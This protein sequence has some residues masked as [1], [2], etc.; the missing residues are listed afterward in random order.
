ME[1]DFREGARGG[2]APGAAPALAVLS[3]ATAGAEPLDP[4]ALLER[5]FALEP[6]RVLRRMPGRETF[7]WPAGEAFVVK[8]YRGEEARDFLYERLRRARRPRSPGRRE[9]ENLAAL[10]A[11]GFDVPRALAWAEERGALS[12]AAARPEAPGARSAVVMERIPFEASFGDHLRRIPAAARAPWLER[13]AVLVARLHARGWYH[14]DLYLHQIV[15]G[16]GGDLVLLD[17][18]RARRERAPRR[19]WHVKD[20]AAL[21]SSAPTG[22]TRAERLRF[23]RRY[24]EL[25]GL[26]L[27]LLLPWARLVTRKAARISAHAPKHVDP[28]S[29]A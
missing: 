15:V 26:D 29:A 21:L 7:A 3:G 19:R 25:R 10:A 20:L 23:L 1:L 2:A 9:W 27:S 11:D 14:R 24:L 18:G 8:R 16:T 22:I 28:G 17:V 6:A 4:R 5:L 12:L 13:L